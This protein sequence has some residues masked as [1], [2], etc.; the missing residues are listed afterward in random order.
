MCGHGYRHSWMSGHGY[1][2][3]PP[4]ITGVNI[5]P[6]PVFA[7][8]G[9]RNIRLFPVILRRRIKPQRHPVFTNTVSVTLIANV[10]VLL[11]PP[12]RA[13]RG[14]RTGDGTL[15][16]TFTNEQL[17]VTHDRTQHRTLGSRNRKHAGRPTKCQENEPACNHHLIFR[18]SSM[19]HKHPPWCT[20]VR[21]LG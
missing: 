9:F 4:D 16:Q 6:V 10:S 17:W 20:C 11:L 5:T 13:V 21:S 2:H 3:Q 8:L 12:R 15:E 1:R 7:A 18:S 19:A 14:A